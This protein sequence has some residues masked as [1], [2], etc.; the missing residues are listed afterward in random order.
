MAQ[1]SSEDPP[2]VFLTCYTCHERL[3]VP[4]RK[5]ERKVA[6]PECGRPVRVPSREEYEAH[7]PKTAAEM[8]RDVGE[9]NLAPVAESPTPEILVHTPFLN[10]RAEVRREVVPPPPTST[11]FTRVFDFPW[12]GTALR[13][14]TLFAFGLTVMFGV[15]GVALAVFGGIG[16]LQ[17]APQGGMLAFFVLPLIWIG[18]WTLSFGAACCLAIVEAT[19][20]GQDDVSEWPEPNWKEWAADMIYVAWL[21]ILTATVAWGASRLLQMAMPQVTMARSLPWIFAALFPIAIISA[22]ESVNHWLPW[23]PFVWASFGRHPGAWIKFYVVSGLVW[24][25]FDLLSIALIDFIGV[26]GMCLAAPLLAAILFIQAR[27][28]GRVAWRLN[29]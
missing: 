11:F 26:I 3:H 29:H 19:A 20:G 9:Y 16:Q 28:V 21:A 13:R 12:R 23:S 5:V 8:V 1:T 14:W 15:L 27:L 2:H 25:L 7:R 22:M 6:C 18:I 10:A 24:F 4:V 17:A